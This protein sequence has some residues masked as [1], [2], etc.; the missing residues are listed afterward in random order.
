M[1]QS[2]CEQKLDVVA[3]IMGVHTS[4]IENEIPLSRLGSERKGKTH[5]DIFMRW[6]VTFAVVTKGE[7]PPEHPFGVA[8]AAYDLANG[9][10]DIYEAESDMW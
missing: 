2:I 8:W 3:L 6:G 4:E 5:P 1:A 9:D 7:K 10:F